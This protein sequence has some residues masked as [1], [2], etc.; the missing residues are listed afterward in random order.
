MIGGAYCSWCGTKLPLSPK[1]APERTTAG[2]IRWRLKCSGCGVENLRLVGS[3]V[4][5][6]GSGGDR[7]DTR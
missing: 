1:K 2:R 6:S 5:G 4:P 3:A 7:E